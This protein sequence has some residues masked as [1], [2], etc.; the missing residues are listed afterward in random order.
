MIYIIGYMG[1]GK[2]TIGKKLAQK[3]GFP[4]IDI[5]E[6]IKQ[7]TQI[8][9]TEIFRIYGELY[10]RSLEKK[11]LNEINT[12]HVVSCGGGLPIY[13]NNMDFIINN[14]K[15]IYLKTPINI[16][17]N[18]LKNNKKERPI[19]ENIEEDKLEDFIRQQSLQREQI[20]NKA[21]Y[22]IKTKEKTEDEVLREINSLI[23]TS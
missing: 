4:F 16:L 10:F 6:E 21:T 2:T 9:I 20:Y 17:F 5:D 22:T 14:G 11:I 13:S 18:R 15:S 1:S 7:Y 8:S 19:I 12:D 3:T 23:I